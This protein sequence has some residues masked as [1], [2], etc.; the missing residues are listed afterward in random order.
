MSTQVTPPIDHKQY[1]RI[2]TRECPRPIRND[3]EL[4]KVI[5]R[6]DELDRRDAEL[7]P[8]ERELAE[9]YTTL[10][11]A[12][13][14]RHYPVRHVAPREFLRALLEQRGL[15]RAD[16]APLLGGSGHTSE[17][18]SGKRAI[19]KAQAKRLAGFFK[20]SPGLFI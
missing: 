18:L 8:E 6:L 4:E 1:G 19:S 17:V 13:E 16:I 10:I 5:A 3:R 11:E 14:E 12:Y 15:R 7:T 20:L 2:L 9:L